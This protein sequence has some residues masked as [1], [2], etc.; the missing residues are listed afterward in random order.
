MNGASRIANATAMLAAVPWLS[1]EKKNNV[2]KPIWNIPSPAWLT[3][4]TVNS[5]RKSRM[6]SS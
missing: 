4:R 5:R 1:G 6:R 2:A 3:I